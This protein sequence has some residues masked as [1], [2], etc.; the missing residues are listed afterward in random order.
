MQVGSA[1]EAGIARIG[2]P[3]AGA[4]HCTGPDPQAVGLKVCIDCHGT[5]IMQYPDLV[6]PGQVTIGLAGTVKIIFKIDDFAGA[7]GQDWR[8]DWH[9]DIDGILIRRLIVCLVVVKPLADDKL[10]TQRKWRVII[11][12]CR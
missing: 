9:D 11:D 4:D 5:V 8:A 1:A 6:G 12:F 2:D 7:S 3:L 10:L